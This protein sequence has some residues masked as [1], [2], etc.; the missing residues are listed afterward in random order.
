M[1]PESKGKRLRATLAAKRS[2]AMTCFA[3]AALVAGC[4]KN[5]Q[6]EPQSWEEISPG[7]PPPPLKIEIVKEGGGRLK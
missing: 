4:G 1:R 6:T 2:A 7:E 5:I 3:L